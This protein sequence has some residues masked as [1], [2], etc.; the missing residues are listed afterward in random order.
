MQEI[1]S[2]FVAS[3]TLDVVVVPRVKEATKFLDDPFLF[4]PDLSQGSD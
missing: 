3:F 4:P 2:N 1:S